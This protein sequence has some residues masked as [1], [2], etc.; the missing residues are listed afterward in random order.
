MLEGLIRRA[1]NEKRRA[2]YEAELI[3]PPMPKGVIYLW[4]VYL[5]IR[6]RKAGNGFGASPIEWPDIDAFVRNSRFPLTPW[7]VECV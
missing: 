5:R 7:E 6:S 4:R 1:S 3:R 2:G